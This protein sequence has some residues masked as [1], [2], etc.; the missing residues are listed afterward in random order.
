MA[1]SS[2]RRSSEGS[3][4]ESV[5]FIPETDN[6]SDLEKESSFTPSGQPPR[7]RCLGYL[8]FHGTLVMLYTTLFFLLTFRKRECGAPSLRDL[9]LYSP[10]EQVIEYETRPV[11]GLAEGSIY[12]GYPR[13]ESETAWRSL[14]EGTNIKLYPDEMGRLNE[15]S[16][17]M[18]DGSGSLAVLGVYHELHC[19]KRLRKWFYREHYYPN[20]TELEFNERMTHADHCLEFLRQ[21][22]MCHGDVTVTS[23]KWLHDAQGHAIEPTTKEG[24]LHRCVKW[25]NLQTWARSRRVDL[26]DPHLLVP[27]HA[28][29][30]LGERR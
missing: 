23:F 15:T 16:L 24:A 20:Q 9:S 30:D 22:S 28:S 19:V 11:D 2:E 25:D 26:F 18:R 6:K 14:M 17:K 3:G 1:S 13:P 29:D 4:E 21:A 12:A 8:S 5:P 10:A 7:W 27:E